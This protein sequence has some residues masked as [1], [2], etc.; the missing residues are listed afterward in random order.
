MSGGTR[1]DTRRIFGVTFN[2][3][4]TD[5]FSPRVDSDI[6]RGYDNFSANLF[7]SLNVG[8][9]DLQPAPLAR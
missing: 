4:Q 9:S 8:S 3:Q 7:G 6:D 1:N 5:G 2:T